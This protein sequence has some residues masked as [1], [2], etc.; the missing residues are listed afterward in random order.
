MK[1]LSPDW[2][3]EPAIDF[4]LKSYHLLAWLKHV[5][6]N[7][8]EKKYFPLI[9]DLKL[10]LKNLEEYQ[11]KN[12]ELIELFKNK[13][14]NIDQEQNTLLSPSDTP[15]ESVFD[16]LNKIVSWSILQLKKEHQNFNQ[17]VLDTLATIQVFPVGL[18]PLYQK[19]GYLFIP[20]EK[21]IAVYEYTFHELYTMYDH[22]WFYTQ[23]SGIGE[24]SLNWFQ[25]YEDLKI[26]LAKQFNKFDVPATFV[27]EYQ[28]EL[29]LQET[30]LP[31][32]KKRL[33]AYL[34]N[35]V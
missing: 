21:N 20:I 34:Q 2:F 16:E 26:E 15:V 18:Q 9:D 3:V 7:L 29:P 12:S 35:Q 11:Q 23:T 8:S 10:Q 25:T 4:E 5:Q 1:K 14:S 28:E 22:D 13:L 31:L 17:Q 32:A 27:C 33:A 19:E 30:L 24:F 6:E